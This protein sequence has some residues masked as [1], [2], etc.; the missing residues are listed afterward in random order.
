MSPTCENTFVPKT[1]SM[2]YCSGECR[3][4]T[5]NDNLKRNYH[6]NKARLKGQLKRTCT[7]CNITQLSR[8]NKDDIC[9][10]CVAQREVDAR[11]TL[12]EQIGAL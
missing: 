11:N 1:V 6:R 10:P 9:E 2:I 4:R 3:T 5:T 12:L 8:Y 7:K